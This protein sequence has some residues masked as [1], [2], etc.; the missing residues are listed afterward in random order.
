[1]IRS[2]RLLPWMVIAMAC[3]KEPVMPAVPSIE[4]VAIGPAQVV[5]FQEPVRVRLAYKDGDG[6]LGFADADTYALFVKDSRLAEADG[7]HVPPLAPPDAGV[8]IQGELEIELHPLFLLGSSAQEE[9]T[10]TIRLRDRAGN[11]SN[12]ITAP[13]IVVMAP[14]P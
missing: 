3:K 12:S 9:V 5:S 13:P 11:W 4:L 2:L 1:M 10:F 6:D 7:Y 8:P 14:I